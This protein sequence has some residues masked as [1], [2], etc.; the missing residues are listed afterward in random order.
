V[1]RITRL[2]EY[3]EAPEGRQHQEKCV[4]YGAR[5]FMSKDPQ[6]QRAEM[7]ALAQGAVRSRDTVTHYV[8]SWKWG[9]QPT[10]PQVESVMD[11][12]LEEFKVKDCQVIYAL[13]A[14]TD[15]FHL[16]IVLNRVDP[17]TYKCI[18]INGGF[19]IDALHRT[20]AKIELAHGW[21]PE[22]NSLYKFD[23]NGELVRRKKEK[24]YKPEQ[25]KIDK[26]MITGEKSAERIAIEKAAPVIKKVNNWEQLHKELAEI[27]MRY[28]RKGSGAIIFVGEIAVKASRVDRGASLGN[29]QKRLGVYKGS[30]IKEQVDVR[31]KSDFKLPAS[32]KEKKA[33]VVEVATLIKQAETWE[34]LHSSLGKKGVQYVK[35]GSGAIVVFGDAEMKA[36]SVS[37]GASLGQ[38]QK[39]LGQYQGAKLEYE[40]KQGDSE[41]VKYNQPGWNDYI[42]E[43]KAYFR[44]KMEAKEKLEYQQEQEAKELREYNKQQRAKIFYR[45]WKQ[46]GV[47]LNAMRSLVA[48]EQAKAK[49]KLKE[50]QKRERGEFREQYKSFPNYNQWRLG[51]SEEPQMFV[52]AVYVSV[53]LKDIRYF[54]TEVDRSFV[55][56]MRE[57]EPWKISFRDTGKRIEV[58]DWQKKETTLAAF[59]VAAEKWGGVFILGTAEFKAMCVELAVEYGFEIRNPG[60]QDDMEA[61]RERKRERELKRQEERKRQIFAPKPKPE[62]EPKP[63]PEQERS[64]APRPRGMGR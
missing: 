15:N 2:T 55:N 57:E 43:R 52:G 42:V 29:L 34:E 23:E 27:G 10:V 17:D 60:L 24:V 36:S 38:L 14:D 48:A 7:I 30:P 63:E 8:L 31:R 22:K 25:G 59:Q 26:E 41:P 12:I 62:L 5:N 11:I 37:R 6:A 32:A 20:V 35:T 46:R 44:A 16:H 9:E 54:V 39:R 19:D 50:K 51:T 13:H 18:E 28:V 58:Y 53:E 47:E 49:A 3:V 56:Y 40:V 21:E 45:D 64:A 1:V 33:L 61:A 4:Y